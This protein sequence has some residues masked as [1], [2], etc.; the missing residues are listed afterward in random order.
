MHFF[1]L[2]LCQL[3]SFQACTHTS[4]RL[5]VACSGCSAALPLPLPLPPLLFC[6]QHGSLPTTLARQRLLTLLLSPRLLL[7][8]HQQRLPRAS[9]SSRRRN[10]AIASLP[11]PRRSCTP[12][13]SAR[14]WPGSRRSPTWWNSA[15]SWS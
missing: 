13:G 9:A 6:C 3:V 4:Q 8:L 7:L 1:T 5:G 10:A 12:C 11:S 15:E 14:C 2:L